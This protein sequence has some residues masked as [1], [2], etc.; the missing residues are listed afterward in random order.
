LP[1]L[2][3]LELHIRQADDPAVLSGCGLVMLNPPFGLDAA[4][5]AVMPVLAERLSVEGRGRWSLDALSPE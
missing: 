1:K 2:A 3:C 5:K 4:L